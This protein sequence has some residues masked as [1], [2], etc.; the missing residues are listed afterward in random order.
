MLGRVAQEFR[1]A[2]IL[3]IRG[4]LTGGG[5]GVLLFETDGKGDDDKVTAWRIGVPS[6]VDY[7]EGCS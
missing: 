7:V 5:N 3:S 4:A 6:Q 1:R 2:R